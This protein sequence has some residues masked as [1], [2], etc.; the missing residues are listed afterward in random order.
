M[1]LPIWFAPVDLKPAVRRPAGDLADPFLPKVVVHPNVLQGSPADR[2]IVQHAPAAAKTSL[3][4]GVPV[5]Q[6]LR[7]GLRH[8]NLQPAHLFDGGF[9]HAYA[10]WFSTICH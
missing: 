9:R 5:L 6:R 7:A 3:L 1:A 2:K 10:A 4:G 8:R